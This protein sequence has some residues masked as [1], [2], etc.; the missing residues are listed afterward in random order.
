MKTTLIEERA[1]TKRHT[2]TLALESQLPFFIPIKEPKL[3]RSRIRR[4]S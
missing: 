3:S 2:T 4:K 1:F